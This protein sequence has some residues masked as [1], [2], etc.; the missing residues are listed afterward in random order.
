[1]NASEVGIAVTLARD[2]YV[3]VAGTAEKHTREH[4]VGV[5]H[6]YVNPLVI[7]IWIG[8]GVMVFGTLVCMYAPPL[9]L[10]VRET[11]RADLDMETA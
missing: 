4:P 1:M 7:W 9:K 10:R 11:V 6:I 8:T 3:V 5:F 2:Y